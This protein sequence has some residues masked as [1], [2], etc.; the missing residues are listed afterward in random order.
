MP[1]ENAAV[2]RLTAPARAPAQ[3]PSLPGM[4]PA[5]DS[6]GLAM[7]RTAAFSSLFA[8]ALA[9]TAQAHFPVGGGD[10]AEVAYDPRR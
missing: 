7:I 4:N 6:K 5:R 2:S 8:L 10:N 3:S 1:R 9:G